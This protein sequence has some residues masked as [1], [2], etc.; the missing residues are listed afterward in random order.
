MGIFQLIAYG[1]QDVYLS[2]KVEAATKI[3]KAWRR[4]DADKKRK[5]VAVIERHLLHHFYKPGGMLA[6][7]CFSS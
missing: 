5:A 2:D 3:Q 1:A 4:H 6:P 7:V